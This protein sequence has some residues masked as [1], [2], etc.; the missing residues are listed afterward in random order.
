MSKMAPLLA[1]ERLPS[2]ND[3]AAAM[4][5]WD[6]RA[7]AS[8][9]QGRATLY[10]F[11]CLRYFTT[12]VRKH[13]AV[14]RNRPACSTER[15]TSTRTRRRRK[16]WDRW[17][18]STLWRSARVSSACSIP[19]QMSLSYQTRRTRRSKSPHPTPSVQLTVRT[20]RYF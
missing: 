18:V 17:P 10:K 9:R 1:A 12:P 4:P 15:S 16:R 5:K 6:R 13:W 11:I 7:T 2:R 3:Y 19:R 14:Q 20:L 8:D